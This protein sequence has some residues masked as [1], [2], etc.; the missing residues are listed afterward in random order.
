MRMWWQMLRMEREKALRRPLLWI[1]LAAVAALIAFFYATFFAFRANVPPSGTQFLYW[2]AGLVYALG[3]VVGYASWAS[4]GTYLLI[5]VI[6]VG[7]T[8]EYSWR[9][10]QLWLS[11]GVRRPALLGAKFVVTLLPALL[12]VC[13]CLVTIGG[14]SALFSWQAQGAVHAEQVNGGEL[15]LSFLRTSYAMLPYAALPFLL[16]VASRS[17]AMAV[18]GGLAFVAVIETALTN[19]LAALGGIFARGVQYLPSGLAGALNSQNAALANLPA[20]PNPLQPSPLAAAIG[21]AAYTLAFAGLALWIFQ[22]Q[23][24]TD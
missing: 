5:V 22:R 17:A 4:Y 23:D 18:G 13:V 7:M 16:A 3:T 20:T 24:L 6:G 11:H 14:L 9:T 12:I 10:L 2:P 1:G 19:T 15:A 21:I 8:Q